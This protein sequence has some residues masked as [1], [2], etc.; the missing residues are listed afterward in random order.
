MK[1]VTSFSRSNSFSDLCGTQYGILWGILFGVLR[2]F[3]SGFPAGFSSVERKAQDFR[4][5]LADFQFAGFLR[6]IPPGTEET[7]KDSSCGVLLAW[8]RRERKTL[9]GAAAGPALARPRALRSSAQKSAPREIIY[10]IL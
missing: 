5:S 1:S 2:G 3:H 7:E 10:E 6:R 4:Q 8:K 9:C